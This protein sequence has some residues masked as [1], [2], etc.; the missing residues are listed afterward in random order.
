M[1]KGFT[2]RDPQ[3]DEIRTF[4]KTKSQ[5]IWIITL[6]EVRARLWPSYI[7]GKRN[8]KNIRRLFQDTLVK[9]EMNSEPLITTDGF[10]LYARVIKRLFG[11]S[12]VYGQVIKIRR[13]DKVIRVDRKLIIGSQQ[14]LD[15][16]LERS[17]DSSTLNT[18]FVKRHN[19]TIRRGNAYFHRLTPS[20]ARHPEYLRDHLELLQCHYNFIRPHS[21][22][23][24]GNEIWTPAMQ[25]GLTTKRLTFRHVFLAA[26]ASFFFV[27]ILCFQRRQN[28]KI[29]ILIVYVYNS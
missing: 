29:Q 28:V 2:R 13:K 16:A 18:S 3:A 9:S 4:I 19:L 8:Y 25:A 23:K 10:R 26:T 15:N 27:S 11:C 17:E 24:Y 5:A 6:I 22:L 7:I 1:L 21:A 12:C 14:R 20:H